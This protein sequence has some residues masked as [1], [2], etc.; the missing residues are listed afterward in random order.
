MMPFLFNLFTY[1]E[2][3]KL[4]MSNHRLSQL[5]FA[6]SLILVIA[7]WPS[8]AVAQSQPAED[9]FARIQEAGKI[10]VGTAADYAPFEFY[11]S[12]YQLDGFDIQ[13]MQ[14]LGQEL[15]VEVEFKDFAFSGLLDALRLGQ[16]DAA[17]GA[18]SVTPDRLQLVDFTNIYYRGDTG[19]LVRDDFDGAI[20]SATDLAGLTVGAEQGTTHQAWVQQNAVDAGVIPQASLISYTDVNGMVR[21]LRNGAIDVVIMGYLPATQISN[22]LP[23]LTVGEAKLNQELFGIAVP[24]GSNLAAELNQALLSVQSDGTFANLVNT[25]LN[26]DPNDAL[27]TGETVVDNDVESEAAPAE[28]CI[29]GMAYVADLNLDDQ[30]MAAPPV[31]NL[32]Q[33]FTKSWRVLNSG[34]CTWA[35]DFEL[36]YVNGNRAEA[37]M[38]GQPVAVGQAVPPGGTLDISANLRAPQ[39]YGVFQGFWQMRDSGKRLFGETVWVGIQI[40]DPN[41][42]APPPVAASVNPNLRADADFVN[43]GQC[44]TIRWDVDN[45][46]AVYFVVAGNVMPKGGH[47]S[48]VV[49]PGGT[50][51]YELRVVRTDGVTETFPITI[52]V[53][54]APNA[55]YHINFWSDDG[56]IEGGRCTTLRWDVQGVRE[57][58]LNGE[59]VPGVSAREVCPGGTTDY[60]L[61]VVRFDGGSER[62][63]VT[64][65]VEGR[66]EDHRGG[67]DIDEF[68]VDR[69]AIGAGQCVRLRWRT[70]DTDGVNIYRS[71]QTIVS[72]GDDDG[73]TEDC[74][75]GPGVYDYVLEA[76]GNG[77]N[78]QS[79]TVEVVRM[80][81]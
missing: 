60:N 81:R 72:R 80:E 65:R 22:F 29:Q 74:P 48:H 30:N 49:C 44:T 76:F 75:P 7:G 53:G 14:A 1:V 35:P 41:P 64:V 59:G 40:P 25:Y 54:G 39:A 68:S 37:A 17:I 27:P 31:M 34:T 11:N 71:G 58:Y 45:V 42:P 18:I 56:E 9:D 36:V 10:V 73:S 55:P 15:G 6:I 23:G 62:R 50:E 79:L 38:G 66:Q 46:S 21:D 61:D 70:G 69:K 5:C 43:S 63:T 52:N 8:P 24:D 28:E 4:T 78:R 13:L 67:P 33:D 32:G 12:S 77:T 57:V 51:T 2:K 26:A 19:T 3:T 16:V 20:G 47:D